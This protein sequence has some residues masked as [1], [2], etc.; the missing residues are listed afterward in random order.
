MSKP[1]PTEWGKWLRA[2]INKH[3]SVASSVH[4]HIEGMRRETHNKTEWIEIRLDGPI[5]QEHTHGQYQIDV[6]V[7]IAVCVV[8]STNAYRVSALMQEMAAAFTQVITIYKYGDDGS[9]FDYITLTPKG[10]SRVQEFNFGR[11]DGIHQG[12]V[13]SRYRGYFKT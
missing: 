2:S 5:F 13:E 12:A 11:V 3:F 9:V 8:Y 1:V 4:V 10:Q 7:N 6:E